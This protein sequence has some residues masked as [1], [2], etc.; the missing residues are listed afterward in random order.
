MALA[1]G[2]VSAQYLRRARLG[3]IFW[4]VGQKIWAEE[5]MKTYIRHCA[6]VVFASEG[7]KAV[8]GQV[9]NRDDGMRTGD[10]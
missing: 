10:G 3:G 2:M 6:G 7:M 4:P 5:E 9:L 8:D 1:G